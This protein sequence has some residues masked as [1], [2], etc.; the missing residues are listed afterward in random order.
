MWGVRE[1]EASITNRAC[2]VVPDTQ[3]T[4]VVAL[5]ASTRSAVS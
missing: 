5:V 1:P 2:N 3:L 4:L